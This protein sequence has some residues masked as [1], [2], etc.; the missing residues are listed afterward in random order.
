M[1][2]PYLIRRL[3]SLEEALA[4][5]DRSE[6]PE[7][8]SYRSWRPRLPAADLGTKDCQERPRA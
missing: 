7:T 5:Q 2:S 6:G 1:P 4:A 3:R 8:G